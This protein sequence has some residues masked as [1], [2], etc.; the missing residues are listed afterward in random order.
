M[1]VRKY[2][3]VFNQFPSR[4][5]W[6]LSAFIQCCWFWRGI[7][8]GKGLPSNLVTSDL[9][10][11]FWGYWKPKGYSQGLV[12]WT[13]PQ[14]G[15]RHLFIQTPSVHP[16]KY[17]RTNP[18]PHSRILLQEGQTFGFFHGY[19]FPS[20]WIFCKSIRKRSNRLFLPLGGEFYLEHVVIDLDTAPFFYLRI[21]RIL[22]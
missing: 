3:S 5:L 6:N 1:K 22:I 7:S 15:H 17:L 8:L 14:S 9:F 10:I 21:F 2:F 16:W 18:W 11:T 4:L 19:F 13:A 12:V 20:S